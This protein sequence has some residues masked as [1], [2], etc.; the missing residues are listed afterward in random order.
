MGD[1]A[2]SSHHTPGKDSLLGE[3]LRTLDDER[4][5]ALVRAVGNMMGSECEPA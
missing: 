4:W 2:S 3:H 1:T 5:R